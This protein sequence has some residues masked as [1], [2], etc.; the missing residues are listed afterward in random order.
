MPGSTNLSEFSERF[1]MST[2][3]TTQGGT[4]REIGTKAVSAGKGAVWTGRVLS[5]LAVLFMLLDAAGKFVMPAGVVQAFQRLGFPLSLG[6]G[7]GVLILVCTAAYVV[8]RTAVFGAVLLSAFFGG[9]VAIQMR[10]GSPMF[11]TV[12]PV[13]FG[14]IVWAGVYLRDCRLR[15]VFPIRR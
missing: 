14:V 10:A 5:T 13:I 2:D 8:P 15:E 12:F 9:A 7:V 1:S 11:E 6:P 4:V 3:T